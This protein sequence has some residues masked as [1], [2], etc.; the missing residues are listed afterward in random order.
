MAISTGSWP[1]LMTL[2]KPSLSR[3]ISL[4]SQN[5]IVIVCLV[6]QQLIVHIYQNFQ[7]AG[8]FQTTSATDNNFLCNL[9]CAGEPPSPRKQ[10]T[11]GNISK[12]C[13]SCVLLTD[14]IEIH[15]SQPDSMTYRRL[16]AVIRGFQSDLTITSKTDGNFGN[17]SAGVLFSKLVYQQKRL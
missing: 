7:N 15:Q 12:I 4:A 2:R 9:C 8:T 10:N 14:R 1:L 13:Q 17:I 5:P 3:A 6:S 16:Q 11:R